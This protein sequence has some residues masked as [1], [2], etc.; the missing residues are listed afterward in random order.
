MFPKVQGK[1]LVWDHSNNISHV[2]SIYWSEGYFTFTYQLPCDCT[3]E[4]QSSCIK[5]SCGEG[6]G[7]LS[8][9][10]ISS[11]SSVEP[12]FSWRCS[13]RDVH[14]S[15]P[16]TRKSNSTA[17]SIEALVSFNNAFTIVLR[18]DDWTLLCIAKGLSGT[19]YLKNK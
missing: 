4:T 12:S 19:A 5:Q 14:S 1:I 8:R 6:A 11:V 18:S 13:A 7:N 3:A 9:Y 17:F 16:H 2:T 15:S 10:S